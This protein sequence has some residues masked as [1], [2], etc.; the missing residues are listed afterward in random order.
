MR[1]VID[2]TSCASEKEWKKYLLSLGEGT[3]V[4]LAKNYQRRASFSALRRMAKQEEQALGIITYI[5]KED[6]KYKEYE[7]V[8]VGLQMDNWIRSHNCGGKAEFGYGFWCSTYNL[9][10]VLD[11]PGSAK[12]IARR[13]KIRERDKK[14]KKR[15]CEKYSLTPDGAWDPSLKHTT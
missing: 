2:K 15:F 12:E 5:N 13:A 10:V 11:S 1:F 14:R 7:S 9:E 8:T 3:C 6:E 4:G